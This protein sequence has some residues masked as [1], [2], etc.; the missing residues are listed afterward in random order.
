MKIW[1]NQDICML[2][3]G[4]K[5]GSG[6]MGNSL[7]VLQKSKH[8]ITTWPSNSAP[9]YIPQGTENRYPHRCT[10]RHIHSSITFN[11]QKAETT[12]VAISGGIN[13]Q[14][15]VY[16]PI[17]YYSTIERKKDWHILQHGWALKTLCLVKKNRQ[18]IPILYDFHLYEIS[19]RGK[20]IKI[21]SRWRLPG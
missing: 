20:C 2:P 13:T 10:F 15:V 7:V 5:H 3:V 6:A 4:V 18:K 1:R 21:K 12:Q 17:G 9:R 14:I 19:R 8:R 16:P 11:S